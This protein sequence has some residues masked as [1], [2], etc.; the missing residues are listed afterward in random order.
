MMRIMSSAVPSPPR[1]RIEII[2]GARG[3][4]MLL[5]FVSHF[6]E[7]FFRRLPHAQ[8]DRLLLVTRIATPAFIWISGATLAVLHARNRNRF[9]KTADRLIDRGLFLIFVGHLLIIPAYRFMEKSW[10]DTI[11]VVFVTDTLGLCVLV[12]AVLITRVDALGRLL[13]GTMLLLSSWALTVI[14]EPAIPSLAWRLKDFLVGDLRDRWLD[15]NFPPLPWLG[16]YLIASAA[17]AV[18]ARAHDSRQEKSYTSR[19]A[20]LGTGLLGAAFIV[21]AVCRGLVAH[22]AGSAVVLDH[23][24]SMTHKL[25]PSPTYMLFHSGLALLMF[26]ALLLFG[27][28]AAGRAFTRWVALFGR[29]S[30]AAFLFQ[31]YFYYLGVTVLPRPPVGLAAL[32]FV[33]TLVLLRMLTSTWARLGGNRLITVGYPALRNRAASQ[34]HAAPGA[35]ELLAQPAAPMPSPVSDRRPTP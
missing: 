34:T 27:R 28:V 21:R 10:P 18:F 19:I 12:G 5:V 11:R 9:A 20:L 22:G 8:A 30:M 15:Y 35:E 3:T 4:A 7:A 31:F 32:Y 17:G 24:A 1:G 14:W 2:D 13:L 16:L 25:P 29:Y 6:V 33:A 26:A 23:L